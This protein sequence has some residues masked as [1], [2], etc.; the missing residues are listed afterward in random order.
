MEQIN[1]TKLDDIQLVAYL[2]TLNNKGSDFRY[3]SEWMEKCYKW[4][5]DK[6]ENEE[7]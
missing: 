4:M 2:A 1:I 3:Q 6:R 5:K 7:Q